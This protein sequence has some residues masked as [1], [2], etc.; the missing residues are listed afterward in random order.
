MFNLES[1]DKVYLA[2]CGFID[3]RKSIDG[4]VLEVQNSLKLDPF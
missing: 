2:S 4:F 3:L 1:I